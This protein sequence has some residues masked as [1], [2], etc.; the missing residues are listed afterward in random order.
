[1]LAF[2]AVPGAAVVAAALCVASLA[3]PAGAATSRGGYHPDIDPARFSTTVDNPWLPLPPGRVLTYTGTEGGRPV[4]DVVT[5]TDRTRR[6]AGVETVVVEDRVTRADRLE[7]S[8]L[9]YYAQDD[10]GTVWYF[11]EDTHTV[12]RRGRIASREGTWHAGQHGAQPGVVMQARPV[13][14]R[15]LRQEYYKGHAQDWYRVTDIARPITVP[16]GT[17]PDALV[18]AEWS[19]LEPGVLDGK[20]YVRGIGTVAEATLEG[21]KET[22]QLTS[23]R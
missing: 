10:A 21:P 16:A 14:G 20:Y 3:V 12:D 7:E 11:G 15:R 5:V 22:L 13:V 8:T 9:D 6:I 17:F 1:M 4:V 18:T 19:P 23:T 2:V